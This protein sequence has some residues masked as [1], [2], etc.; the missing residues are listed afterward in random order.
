MPFN[1]FSYRVNLTMMHEQVVI[2]SLFV[3][4]CAFPFITE[5]TPVAVIQGNLPPLCEPVWHKFLFYA[6]NLI[7]KVW[8]FF[9]T[10]QG[11]IE[12][13]PTHIKKVCLALENS[14]QLS[15]ALTQYI[16]NEAAGSTKLTSR[17]FFMFI[18][19]ILQDFCHLMADFQTDLNVNAIY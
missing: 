9:D 2:L 5:S 6:N 15:S 10:Q 3:A 17:T 19:K 16:R 1:P 4:L 8:K 13:M 12:E 18:E 14:N 11:V 7:Y